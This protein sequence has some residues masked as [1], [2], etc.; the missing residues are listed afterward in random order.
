LNKIKKKKR[1]KKLS[2]KEESFMIFC[3]S[4]LTNISKVTE[5]KKRESDG[6]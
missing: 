3:A 5:E 4:T 6:I 2:L 1:K